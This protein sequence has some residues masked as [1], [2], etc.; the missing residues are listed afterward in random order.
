MEEEDYGRRDRDQLPE[1]A[2]KVIRLD[3]P[4]YL[5]ADQFFI[6][7]EVETGHSPQPIVTTRETLHRRVRMSKEA[8]PLLRAHPAGL[9]PHTG[10]A[11]WVRSITFVVP[12]HYSCL[13][14]RLPRD[15]FRLA[16]MN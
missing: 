4:K 3:A 16:A 1:I 9:L 12:R 15:I 7:A 13:A 14:N 5:T 10:V 6:V 8:D 11:V 2:K